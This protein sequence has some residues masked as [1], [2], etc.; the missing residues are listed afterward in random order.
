MV[1]GDCGV[2]ESGW[3]RI[4]RGLPVGEADCPPHLNEK[5]LAV[6]SVFLFN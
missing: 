5:G 3:C 4:N 6:I 1:V 2:G